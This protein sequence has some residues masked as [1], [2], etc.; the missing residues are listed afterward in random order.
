M[1]RKP[2]EV[3]KRVVKRVEKGRKIAAY[4]QEK[5]REFVGICRNSSESPDARKDAAGRVFPFPARGSSS[6]GAGSSLGLV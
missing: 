4:L 6:Q 5:G 1:I 2:G 3:V